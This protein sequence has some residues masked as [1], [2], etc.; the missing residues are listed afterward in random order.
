MSPLLQLPVPVKISLF[1]FR[2]GYPGGSNWDSAVSMLISYDPHRIFSNPY[3][4][5]L[6]PSRP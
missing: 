6:M 4:D 5:T 3:L 2:A 1:G